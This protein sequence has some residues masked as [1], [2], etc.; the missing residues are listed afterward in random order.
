[1]ESERKIPTSTVVLSPE[2]L[3][4]FLRIGEEIRQKVSDVELSV[5]TALEKLN[6]SFAYTSK[7][8]NDPRIQ[9]KLKMLAFWEIAEAFSRGKPALILP[10]NR[11]KEGGSTIVIATYISRTEIGMDEA[12]PIFES[13][14]EEGKRILKELKAGYKVVLRPPEINEISSN[15]S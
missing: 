14:G 3:K 11:N 4:N 12:G 5:K 8:L 10:P 1:M 7:H 6:G 13:V 9:E 15:G 2:G